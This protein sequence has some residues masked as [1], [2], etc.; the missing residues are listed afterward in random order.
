MS[1]GLAE[2]SGANSVSA[3]QDGSDD[4]DPAVEVVLEAHRAASG[5]RRS[6]QETY[7]VARQSEVQIG[8][9]ITRDFVRK[10]LQSQCGHCQR[11]T[12]TKGMTKLLPWHPITACCVMERNEIDLLSLAHAPCRVLADDQFGSDV[13]MKYVLVVLDVFSKFV[14]LSAIPD[15]R[16]ESVIMRLDKHYNRVGFPSILQCDNGREFVALMSL[17][18]W[19]KHGV[20]VSKTSPYSPEENGQVE[21]TVRSLRSLFE[22]LHSES[23][24]RPWVDML[25]DVA[26]AH[27]TRF[28]SGCC[29]VP[30]EVFFGRPY[31]RT[32]RGIMGR[33][34]SE[35]QRH[36]P[37]DEP[38]QTRRSE[39]WYLDTR[40][41]DHGLHKLY[42][43]QRT[44]RGTHAGACSAIREMLLHSTFA[45][46]INNESGLL[47]VH[48]VVTRTSGVEEFVDNISAV[49]RTPCGA[50]T[51]TNVDFLEFAE[52]VVPLANTNSVDETHF[53]HDQVQH[54]LSVAMLRDNILQRQI[55]SQHERYIKQEETTELAAGSVVAIRTN[56]QHGVLE[57]SSP[58]SKQRKRVVGVL[59]EAVSSDASG[60]RKVKVR[61]H[62]SPLGQQV[63]ASKLSFSKSPG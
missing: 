35:F 16:P 12:S 13:V 47:H 18:Y 39:G 44:N 41:Q 1:D 57:S 27:N 45:A 46:T 14:F 58:Y 54:Y 19:S 17:E 63:S 59:E 9:K 50:R 20:V 28:H 40:A 11:R 3:P 43:R 29:S 53:D 2:I 37:R 51:L 49:F 56:G 61:V 23:P 25:D 60:A 31:R 55:H 7:Q 8:R 48:E 38:A 33:M 21:R 26:L 6:I 5:R 34:E 36:E 24:E 15:K 52:A 10:V 4:K 22:D 30:F 62:G 42:A 32:A